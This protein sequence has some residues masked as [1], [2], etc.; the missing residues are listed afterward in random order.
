MAQDYSINP[1]VHIF[2]YILCNNSY[3]P[4]YVITSK[5]YFTVTVHFE[6]IW[7]QLINRE[8]TILGF[9]LLTLEYTLNELHLVM[10]TV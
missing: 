6:K 2:Q 1:V 7:T 3:F 9:L 5:I 8:T 4:K 10:Y